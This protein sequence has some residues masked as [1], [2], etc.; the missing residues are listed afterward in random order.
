MGSMLR[1]VLVCMLHLLRYQHSLQL[2]ITTASLKIP[3]FTTKLQL[4]AQEV[5]ESRKI[6]SVRIHVERVI[7]LVRRKNQI[8]QSRAMPT[9][10]MAVKP[11]ETIALIDKIGV[12]CCV[13]T[14]LSNSIV[15]IG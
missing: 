7:G 10:H 8:L 9:E 5:E 11:G 4:F 13:L 1:T 6:A 15:P 12:I 3:A 14:N 2:L